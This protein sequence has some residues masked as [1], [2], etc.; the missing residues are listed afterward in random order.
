[1]RLVALLTG[2]AGLVSL[3]AQ[4]VAIVIGTVLQDFAS[5]MPIVFQIANWGQIAFLVLITVFFFVFALTK[6]PT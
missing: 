5:L 3:S 6:R 2:I 4:V 1:M